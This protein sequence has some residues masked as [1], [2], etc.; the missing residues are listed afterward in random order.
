M[1]KAVIFDFDGVLVDSL[2]LAVDA[3][4]ALFKKLGAIKTCKDKDEFRTNFSMSFDEH[5]AKYG[6]V[7]EN[8]AK[9]FGDF[10]YNYLLNNK[11][12]MKPN[13]A[14]HPVL[15]E[16]SQKYKLAVVSS[17]WYGVVHTTLKDHGI[18]DYFESISTIENPGSKGERLL[19]TLKL[20]GIEP[21]E[22]IYV[23][24]M[25]H[26]VVSGRQ[27]QIKTTIIHNKMSWNHKKD[28]LKEDPEIIIEHPEQLLEVLEND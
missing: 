21:H 3:N 20:L 17:S 11:H 24:D 25:V 18:L 14:M 12:K 4:N 5:F 1:I 10:Y 26:D 23:G 19:Q 28:I 22:A 27:A 9:N 8:P 6:V 13:S 16:L 15:K 7:V 2:P